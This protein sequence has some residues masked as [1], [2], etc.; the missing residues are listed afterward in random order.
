M[1]ARVSYLSYRPL[2]HVEQLA[3]SLPGADALALVIQPEE[4]VRESANK[5]PA[6]IFAPPQ[7]QC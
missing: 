6:A 2:L 3:S 4:K 7:P 5:A 1:R